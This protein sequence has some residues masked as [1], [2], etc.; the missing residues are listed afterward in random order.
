ME[1][2][3]A[4][5]S[6]RQSML[7]LT[8]VTFGGSDATAA[9]EHLP[10]D[11]AELLKHRANELL[12]IPK[13]KRIPL[14]VQEIKR[15]VTLRR[16]NLS[17]A[18]PE[19]LALLLKDERAALVEVLL[20]ALPSAMAEQVRLH[21]PKRD[22]ALLKEVKPDILNIV[23]WK[24]EEHLMRGAPKKGVFKFTDVLILQ[25]REL[26]T[27]CDRMG[28]RALATAIAGLPDAEREAFL[29]ALPPD[30]RSMAQKASE[31][32]MSRKLNPDDARTVLE[33]HDALKNPSAG[34][35][36]AGTQR[37]AR[38]CLMQGLDF[39]ERLVER[40]PGEFGKLLARW[41]ER[42][43]PRPLRGDGG[44]NDIVEQ[45]ERLA[46]KGIID[47]PMRLP[48][49]PKRPVLG[50]RGALPSSSGAMLP[51]GRV[52]APPPRPPT[53]PGVKD[54]RDASRPLPPG[55]GLLSR[56]GPRRDAIAE[57]EARRAGS[58]GAPLG[59]YRDP[60]AAREARKAGAAMRLRQAT[61]GRANEGQRGVVR[62][63]R[64]GP[65][66]APREVTNP[67]IL[68]DG[69]PIER[70]A[71]EG[72]DPKRRVSPVLEKPPQRKSPAPDGT[73]V[74][75]PSRPVTGSQRGIIKGRGG[76][77]DGGSG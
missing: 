65:V 42:E 53:A 15:L 24:L 38:A 73:V 6:K 61:D 56:E 55:R 70:S 36:S 13:E 72:T 22:V 33:I 14:L 64:L 69:K 19:R 8:A 66:Q 46:Q 1:R 31:A 63:G 20:R 49:P 2:F 16:K 23:R 71:R 37:L 27:I 11:E 44:R 47:R 25:Q 45:M 62:D 28:A 5:L 43:K 30:Q 18:D 12:Q 41:V 67:R 10:A 74:G 77:R 50:E 75:R 57:R 52:V 39:A 48:P 9:L 68:R 51:G 60:I 40:H 4:S 21:L 59:G 35:R 54:S 3:F 7:L 26:I 76:G 29:N 58:P 17:G 32:G 34:M